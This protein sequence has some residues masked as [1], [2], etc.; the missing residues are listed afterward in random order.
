[1]L[2]LSWFGKAYL[3][4]S[5]DI[6]AINRPRNLYALDLAIFGALLLDVLHYLLVLLVVQELL[7]SHHVHQAQDLGRDAAHLH[8]GVCHHPRYLQRHRSLI[9]T[10]LQRVSER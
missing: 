5:R 1:M 8:H 4:G 3:A 9:Y 7:W 6:K 10:R 2:H